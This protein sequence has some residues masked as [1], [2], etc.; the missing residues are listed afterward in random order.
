MT[1]PAPIPV[2]RRG[3]GRSPLFATL[4]R[5]SFINC[6]IFI[7]VYGLGAIAM[8]AA[9][10][11]PLEEYQAMMEGQLTMFLGDDPAQ[12]ALVEQISGLLHASGTTL[13]LILLGRTVLRLIGA[14]LMWRGD[15]E[16]FHIYAAAQL[17]GIF[18]PHV[19]LPWSMLGFFGPLASVATTALYG[20]Q[21][22][23]L[24]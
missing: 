9:Q 17:L 3:G 4:G 1:D 14:L 19:V 10:R 12:R 24:C 18:A 22:K 21:A 13:M 6:G 11:M 2:I 23:Y 7:V 8:M 20:T 15:K 16:G 5:L